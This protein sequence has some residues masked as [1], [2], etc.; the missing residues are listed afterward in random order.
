MKILKLTLIALFL[1]LFT[2]CS[3]SDDEVF[4]ENQIPTIQGLEATGVSSTSATFSSNITD[5]GSSSVTERGIVWSSTSSSPTKQ[6]NV[7]PI[8]IVN[9]GTG[10]SV[11]TVTGMERGIS[12]FVRAYAE[13]E[14][15]VGYSNQI[16]ITTLSD[17]QIGDIGEAGGIVFYDKGS[18]SDG[19]R[20]LES[21]TENLGSPVWGCNNALMNANY[22]GLGEGD[23]N[24]TLI[25]NNCDDET[26]AAK[27]CN[28]YTQNGF[29]DWY[30]PSIDELQLMIINERNTIGGFVIGGYTSST[31]HSSTHSKG[32]VISSTGIF[33]DNRLK[34]NNSAV[35][36]IRKF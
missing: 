4:S 20:Y 13:N 24:T 2:N 22:T 16:T 35:R 30:L 5:E 9:N 31:E 7:T 15:G 36:A 19:W 18:Y 27:L 1:S 29:N 23:S 26:S 3:S 25:V 6:D 21:T 11:I 8:S 33:E 10:I 32:Y 17:Y 12:Y 34:M 14:F 28:N